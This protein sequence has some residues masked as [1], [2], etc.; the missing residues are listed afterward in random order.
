MKQFALT[1]LALLVVSLSLFAQ[2]V[3][4]DDEQKKVTIEFDTTVY[5]YG[6]IDYASDGVCVFTFTNT[7]NEPIVISSVRASCGCTVPSWTKDP[8]KPKEK[9]E[10]KVKY[11]T[12]IPGAFNKSITV[13]SNGNPSRVALRAKGLVKKGEQ[14]HTIR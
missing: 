11:N 13:L 14:Q 7:G 5:D 12:Y 9:G 4:A 8:I 3:D 2:E 1:V 6:E 10:I